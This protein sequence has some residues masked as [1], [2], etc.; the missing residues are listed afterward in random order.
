VSSPFAKRKSIVET[1]CRKGCNLNEKNKEYL[2]PLHIATGLSGLL[3]I[4]IRRLVA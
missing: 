2:T 3:Y 1:L 4:I